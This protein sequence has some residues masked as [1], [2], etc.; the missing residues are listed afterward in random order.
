MKGS[1]KV[2]CF[3]D[4]NVFIYVFI[5]QD[6]RKRDIAKGLLKKNQVILST[7]VINEVLANI[8][9]K[10]KQGQFS[11]EKAMKLIASFYRKYEVVEV[12]KKLMTE[13]CLLRKN[14][15]FSFW[16][17]LIVSG[18]LRGRCE[19]LYSEDMH[20]GLVIESRLGIVNPFKEQ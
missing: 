3:V 12:D 20:D 13:A 14:Y 16:D 17:G 9:K 5:V 19:V 7:Q 4:T 2:R 10:G 11:E 6:Q 15:K 18:A 8:L 1:N